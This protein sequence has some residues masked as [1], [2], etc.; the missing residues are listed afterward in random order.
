MTC[1]PDTLQ[2]SAGLPMTISSPDHLGLQSRK[3][4]MSNAYNNEVHLH[5]YQEIPSI[6]APGNAIEFTK[7]SCKYITKPDTLIRQG[8][9]DA[10]SRPNLPFISIVNNTQSTI[11]AH[12]SNM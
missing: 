9:M 3:V 8:C 10:H 1:A 7:V 12:H 5:T 11:Q 2:Q 6:W 4:Q